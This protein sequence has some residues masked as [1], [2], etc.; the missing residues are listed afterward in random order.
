MGYEWKHQ[1]EID[2]GRESTKL[3]G[4]M[5]QESYCPRQELERKQERKKEIEGKEEDQQ[6]TM[7]QYESVDRHLELGLEPIVNYQSTA[8]ER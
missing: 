6:D 7:L 5:V 4:A 3:Y 1:K 2:G 8:R